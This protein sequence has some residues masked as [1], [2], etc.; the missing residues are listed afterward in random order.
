MRIDS[1]KW[2]H[3]AVVCVLLCFACGCGEKEGNIPPPPPPPPSSGTGNNGTGGS[4]GSGSTGITSSAITL[5]NVAWTLDFEENFDGTSVNTQ[6]WSM[7]NSQGHAGHGLRRPSAFSV[8]D[9]NLVITA[10]MQDDKVVSGGMRHRKDYLYPV[11]FEFRARCEEDPSLAMSG[12]VLTWPKEGSK[13][14]NGELDVFETGHSRQSRRPL[15]TFIHYR[16]G[17]QLHKTHD[18]DASEWQEMAMDW[19]E[20]SLHIYLN[21][22]RVWDINDKSKVPDTMHHIC[23][24][25][26]A[27]EHEMKGTCHMYVDYVRIY[28]GSRK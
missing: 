9:G 10:E 22:E 7:Y 27:F 3:A 13:E 4:G 12:V 14:D 8:K 28:T 23:L 5:D 25:L 11:R 15:N 18:V 17:K 1:F 26:D 16:G 19:F 20:N 6:N 24:Q 21:G 2:M